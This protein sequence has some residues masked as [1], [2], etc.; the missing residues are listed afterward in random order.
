[1]DPLSVAHTSSVPFFH[2]L[3]G[4]L[5]PQ[6][7]RDIQDVIVVLLVM[8]AFDVVSRF[9][10]E[11][12]KCNDYRGVANTAS[13]LIRGLW[14]ALWGVPDKDNSA[15][16]KRFL[17]SSDLRTGLGWKIIIY[18]TFISVGIWVAYLPDWVFFGQRLDEFA[19]HLLIM[20]PVL[21]ELYSIFEN[22]LAVNRFM[23]TK[24]YKML[25][26]IRDFIKG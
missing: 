1:M 9:L 23:F 11:S 8:V 5:D 20:S 4:D 2:F 6:M 12:K 16:I 18:A 24:L 21:V 25:V 10:T 14:P 26:L 19:S 3:Y 13:N 7:T 22:L 15:E 17:M